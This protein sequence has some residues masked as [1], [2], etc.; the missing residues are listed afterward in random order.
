MH[1]ALQ[2]LEMGGVARVFGLEG[3]EHRLALAGGVDAALDADL[4]D[5]ASE[6]K[7]GGD[8]ADRADDRIFV[9][10]DL[11]AGEREHVAAGGRDILGEGQDLHALF[12]ARAR[13]CGRGSAPPARA[14]RRAS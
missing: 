9:R 13:G 2:R 8:D 14:S 7:T 1:F 11:I 10:V 3:I 12:A 6:A 4:F 5:Q